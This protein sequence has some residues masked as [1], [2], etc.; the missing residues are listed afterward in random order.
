[1]AEKIDLPV[2]T[3]LHSYIRSITP[4]RSDPRRFIRKRY[5]QLKT[6]GPTLQGKTHNASI[7]TLVSG[8]FAILVLEQ[9]NYKIQH[10]QIGDKHLFKASRITST[11]EHYE[12]TF[13]K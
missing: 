4:Q 6:S 2:T 1:M 11:Q 3:T 10:C 5:C 9:Q 8:A 13:R 12:R 7:H